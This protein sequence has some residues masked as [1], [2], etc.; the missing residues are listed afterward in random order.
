MNRIKGNQ[1]INLKGVPCP[2]NFVKTKLKLETMGTGEVLEVELDDGEP[3][4]NVTASVKEEGHQILK[5]EKADE[6]WKLLIKK[7]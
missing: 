2:L 4:T 5:V 1:Y 6:Y 3:I 7:Q